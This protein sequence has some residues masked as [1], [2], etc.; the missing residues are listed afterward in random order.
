MNSQKFSRSFAR[1]NLAVKHPDGLEYLEFILPCLR[2]GTIQVA[3]FPLEPGLALVE[4][5][6][7]VLASAIRHGCH[8]LVT[9]DKT[10]FGK[11]YGRVIQGVAIHS[12]RSIAEALLK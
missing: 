8:A 5:D 11:L 12:P 7:P 4:K 1:R 6:R 10:H 3:D 2:L 9:G